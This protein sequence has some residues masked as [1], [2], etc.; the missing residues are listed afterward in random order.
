MANNQ[1]K[2]FAINDLSDALMALSTLILSSI[3][4]LDKFIEYSKEAMNICDQY[5]DADTIPADVYESISDKILF[6]QRELLEYMA[7]EAHDIF[8]YKTLRKYLLKKNYLTRNLD[9][10]TSEVLNEL[11]TIRN[12]TFHNVQSRLVAE[13]EAMEKTVPS[14]LVGIAKIEPQL[15]PIIVVKY[16]AY[17]KTMMESFIHHNLTRSAQFAIILDEMKRDYQDMYDQLSNLKIIAVPGAELLVEGCESLTPVKTVIYEQV[18]GI[19]G[20]E[21]DVPN[22]SMAIQKGKYDGTQESFD[23]HTGRISE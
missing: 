17:T 7:D 1:F 14:E 20:T 15:N 6:R 18:F 5:N 23:K 13:K 12:W 19:K 21:S 4:N 8:S 22:I 11:H 3:S 2:Q 9:Q 10:E 16:K